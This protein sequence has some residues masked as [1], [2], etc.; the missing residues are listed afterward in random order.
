MNLS[1]LFSENLAELAPGPAPLTET[2]WQLGKAHRLSK[3]VSVLP[4]VR[5]NSGCHPPSQSLPPPT[6]YRWR[7]MLPLKIHAAILTHT[8]HNVKHLDSLT[9]SSYF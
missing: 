8:R 1:H 4:W 5:T 3:R 9:Y 2:S 7:L 6:G